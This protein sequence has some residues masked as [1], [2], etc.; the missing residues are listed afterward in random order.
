MY[1]YNLKSAFRYFLKQKIFVG[2]NLLGLVI[3]FAV[4]SLIMLYVINEL[5]YDAMHKNSKQIYRVI[6]NMQ[7]VGTTDALTTLDLGPLI[8]VN[9]PEVKKMSRMTKTKSWIIINEEESLANSIFID[10]DFV[11]MFTLKGQEQLSA[12]LLEEPN[13]VII[14]TEIANKVFGERFPVGQE[15]KIK[16]PQGEYFFQVKGVID[17]FSKFSSISGDLLFNFSFYHKNLCSAFIESYPY[18]TTFLMVSAKTEISFLEDKINKV[19]IEK[20]TGISST[21]Y[22][23]QKYSRMYLHSDYLS[24]SFYN[25]GNAR[26]LYGLI[27]LITLVVLT[28][29][30]N[31]GILSTACALTR[32]KEI[33][34]RKINGASVKQVKKQVMLESYLLATF[35]L[36]ISLFIAK[37]ILPWFNKFF[38]RKLE[39]S[40]LDSLP[41]SL[42]ILGLV[43]LVATVSGIFTSASTS[44]MTPAG[45]LKKENTKLRMGINLNKVLLTVQMVIVIWF[46][47]VAFLIF[48][49]INFAQSKGLGYNPE[50]LMVFSAVNPNWNGNFENPETEDPNKLQDLMERLKQHQSI[51]DVTL[52]HE[53]PPLQDQLGSGSIRIKETNE[54]YRIA[55]IDGSVNFP[56][57][58]GYKLKEG[59][60]FSNDY[61]G[62]AKNDILINEAAVRYLGLE[63]PV[64]TQ[65][66]MDGAQNAQ[67]I[68]VVYDFNFQSMR[69]E[70]VPL[71][72][73]KT[74][75]FMRQ[76]DVVVRYQPE[77]G[78]EASAYLQSTFNVM[79]KGYETE[80]IFHEDKMKTLYEKEITEARVITLGIILAVFISMMGIF[81]ISLFSISQRVK[82][83]GIRKINGAKT[84]N[85]LMLINLNIARWVVLAFIIATP[86]AWFAMHKWLENFAYKTELS[87]WIFALAGLLALG[88]ALLTVS[89]QSW[90]AATRNP[91]EA[92]RYE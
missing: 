85:I 11:E 77:M 29:C 42:S 49:Q 23:L 12:S 72:V 15:I 2:I 18:F 31:F 69:K 3:A 27:F 26:I 80:L 28:A 82:E 48:K 87:W 60:Y 43:I 55:S 44:K 88:I 53:T 7:G 46:L 41:F 35:A 47:A 68:G 78:N 92:L 50:N 84:K 63:K 57:M 61:S 5:K 32:S 33:G 34:V 13:S 6:N 14:T 25:K 20:W 19:N 40:F 64:G 79:Y 21:K 17:N 62:D 91:V 8:K 66:S 73:R 90:R 58:L 89:W 59:S 86:L 65:I 38:N 16:F 45:L 75:R 39:F 1:F 22:E 36:P 9:M 10:P 76:F 52:L 51:K 54:T 4:S 56:E 30:L 70:I 83:I 67:I 37:T 71:R 81:G 24:N 74:N